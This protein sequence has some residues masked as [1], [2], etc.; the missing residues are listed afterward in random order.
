MN[1]LNSSDIIRQAD[2]NSPTLA[3]GTAALK[4]VRIRIENRTDDKSTECTEKRN[5]SALVQYSDGTYFG[6]V[7]VASVV[8]PHNP[9]YID[10]DLPDLVPTT[11]YF[12]WEERFGNE[13]NHRACVFRRDSKAVGQPWDAVLLVFDLISMSGKPFEYCIGGMWGQ[14]SS[15][16]SHLKLENDPACTMR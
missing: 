3:P 2:I 4:K 14:R 11:A 6:P 10:T 9:A 5:V 8:P 13:T 16:L 15:L 1:T 12:L 7:S